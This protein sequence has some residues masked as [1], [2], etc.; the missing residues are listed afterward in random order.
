MRG[1][2]C[3]KQ[4]HLRK[5]RRHELFS[6]TTTMD[7]RKRMMKE[8]GEEAVRAAR[9]NGFSLLHFAAEFGI[10]TL[11]RLLLGPYKMDPNTEAA[12]GTHPMD[13]AAFGIPG[14]DRRILAKRGKLEI[15]KLLASKGGRFSQAEIARQTCPR[16]EPEPVPPVDDEYLHFR[17]NAL[18]EMNWKDVS[19]EEVYLALIK[20]GCPIHNLFRGE[21]KLPASCLH[22]GLYTPSVRVM[23]E[24]A[25]RGFDF[26]ELIYDAFGF[27]ETNTLQD[28]RDNNRRST[29]MNPS[30]MQLEEI[31]KFKHPLH[32]MRFK[33]DLFRLALLAGAS[34]YRDVQS[35]TLP[36]IATDEDRYLYCYV[37][38]PGSDWRKRYPTEAAILD[39][40]LVVPLKALCLRVVYRHQIPHEHLPPLLFSWPGVSVPAPDPPRK[41]S[42]GQ[43]GGAS[44][45][46]R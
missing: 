35:N 9:N 10:I 16:W 33:K 22:D 39:E 6:T 5:C 4:E 26:N 8:W 19:D 20:A 37:R 31:P 21:R 12:N 42:R 32:T 7:S 1:G 29:R 44:K 30:T 27:D 23:L 3:D 43:G 38:N 36:L 34:P 24:L 41:R 15:I 14:T 45:K 28:E 40:L 13:V 11:A 17:K 46:Q 18:S 25:K 2:G